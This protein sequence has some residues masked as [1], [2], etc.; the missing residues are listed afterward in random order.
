MKSV[1]KQKSALAP[2][3]NIK[4]KIEFENGKKI[5]IKKWLEYLCVMT[6]INYWVSNKAY[7]SIY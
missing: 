3:E 5:D 4:A 6:D 2:I 1:S 7:Y